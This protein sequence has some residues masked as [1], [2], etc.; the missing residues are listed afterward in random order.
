MV[1]HILEVNEYNLYGGKIYDPFHVVIRRY[2]Q[3]K[4]PDLWAVTC[5]D[6]YVLNTDGEWR[7]STRPSNRDADYLKY[8][9]FVTPEDAYACWEASEA[10]RE[11]ME[12]GTVSWEE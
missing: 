1:D 7:W 10:K 6:H 2:P 9:R 3:I 8:H 5:N 4:G 11:L 12:D